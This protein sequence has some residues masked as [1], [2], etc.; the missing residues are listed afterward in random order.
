MLLF[1]ASPELPQQIV[2]T[3]LQTPEFLRRTLRFGAGYIFERKKSLSGYLRPMSY[4]RRSSAGR[5]CVSI[6][7]TA[8]LVGFLGCTSGPGGG[9]IRSSVADLS[10][11]NGAAVL[12][13]LRKAAPA[14]AG[15]LCVLA[16]RCSGTDVQIDVRAGYRPL[17][18]IGCETCT[19]GILEPGTYVLLSRRADSIEGPVAVLA[20]TI[21]SGKTLFVFQRWDPAHTSFELEAMNEQ[22]GSDLLGKQFPSVEGAAQDFVKTLAGQT[23]V[24]RTWERL[25]RIEALDAREIAFEGNI[26]AALKR[27]AS[28]VGYG[29]DLGPYANPILWNTLLQ[30]SSVFADEESGISAEPFSEGTRRRL[31]SIEAYFSNVTLKKEEA[32]EGVLAVELLRTVLSARAMRLEQDRII[33]VKVEKEG[34]GGGLLYDYAER[35]DGYLWVFLSSLEKSVHLASAKGIPSDTRLRVLECI[36]QLN[37]TTLK[38]GIKDAHVHR[39]IRKLGEMDPDPVVRSRAERLTESIL[40]YR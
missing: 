31:E 35:R 13:G 20:V 27:V 25:F 6:V 22:S 18:R 10:G 26:E 30:L 21:R 16:S 14:D 11:R 5:S 36:D 4:S 17:G 2:I 12:N 24:E 34:T 8:M 33:R 28:V 3:V 7:L 9:S 38:G 19:M 29:R 23:D 1:V 32:S 40:E 37:T 15:L 39:E